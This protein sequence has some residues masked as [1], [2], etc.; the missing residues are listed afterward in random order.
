MKKNYYLYGFLVLLIAFIIYNYYSANEAEENITKLLQEQV[1]EPSA[2][3]SIQYANVDVSPFQGN[4]RFENI[5]VT[6]PETIKRASTLT[7]DLNYW[8]F[9]TFNI[10]GIKYGLKHLSDALIILDEPEWVDR[11]TLAE[12]SFDDL[13]IDYTGN[14]W[15]AIQSYFTLIPPDQAHIITLNGTKAAYRRPESSIGTFM[16]D[17][18][19]ARLTFG[20]GEADGQ[21]RQNRIH[22]N[23]ITWN[24]PEGFT[25]KY[26][27][28][29]QGFGL[30]TDSVSFS[31]AGFSYK[32]NNE[33]IKITD[34]SI[35]MK[36]FTTRF[37]GSI[38][39]EPI[40]RFTPLY[41]SII[42]LSPGLENALQNLDQLFDLP[43]P[44]TE[45][46]IYF[47]LEGP[48]T[49]PRIVFNEE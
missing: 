26:A 19:Y 42:K 17:S 21:E 30:S 40:P 13:T 8:D 11:R 15:A 45:N 18:V 48:V 47:R 33:R 5:T 6:Q 12:I 38:D 32:M 22:L 28:I 31:E 37:Y 35:K 9:L 2:S 41:V 27:F 34:G 1:D 36:L 29:M 46:G 4:I 24:P 7:L 3:L 39:R 49:D 10:G 43:I 23:D 14:A 16:A 44:L 25:K 20:I